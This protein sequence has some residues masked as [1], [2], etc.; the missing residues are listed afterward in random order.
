[1]S[2]NMA[3]LTIAGSHQVVAV[4]LCASPGTK[5]DRIWAGGLST[6][7]DDLPA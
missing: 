6:A 5:R 4:A 7:G 3:A 1:M 2:R